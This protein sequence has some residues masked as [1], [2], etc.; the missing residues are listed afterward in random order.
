MNVKDKIIKARKLHPEW[1]IPKHPYIQNLI[2]LIKKKW[3][4]NKK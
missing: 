1:I 4:V 2:N 3:R